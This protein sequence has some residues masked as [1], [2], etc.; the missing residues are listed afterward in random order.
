MSV[1]RQSGRTGSSAAVS[2]SP[3]DRIRRCRVIRPQTRARRPL[4]LAGRRDRR[5]VGAAAHP[6][7]PST[8]RPE[9]ARCR[10]RQRN[11]GQVQHVRHQRI[12]GRS[13]SSR[14]S[15]RP[16]SIRR[17]PPDRAQRLDRAAHPAPARRPGRAAGSRSRAAIGM[18]RRAV[19]RSAAGMRRRPARS[20]RGPGQ[21]GGVVPAASNRLASA[22]AGKTCPDR[23]GYHRNAHPLTLP[24]GSCPHP[25]RTNVTF[26][27]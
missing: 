18:S 5:T 22:A 9:P 16:R 8:S 20:H 25:F 12:Q 13:S 21:H 6:P 11:R 24:A 1:R 4:P 10:R 26:A 27:R 14:P 7:R 2:R 15:R 3:A 23:T 19:G 17:P